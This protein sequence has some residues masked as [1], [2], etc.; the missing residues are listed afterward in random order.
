LLS[1]C[2]G[3]GHVRAA[4]SE[5]RLGARALAAQGAAAYEQRDFGRALELFERA[6]AL[7]PA[8][9]LKLMEARALVEL[10]RF[11]EAADRYTETERMLGREPANEAFRQAAK[12]AEVERAGVL[13]RTPS[14]RVEVVGAAP[15]DSV[16]L[17]IDG[18]PQPPE[19]AE[20]ARPSDPGVH[21]IEARTRSGAAGQSSVTL[22]EGMHADV[23]VRLV[24]AT[25][26]IA[27]PASPAPVAP[28]TPI[29][30]G[31]SSSRRTVGWVMAASGAAA[32]VV[33]AV[34]G[35]MALN[36]KAALDAVCDPL[37]PRDQAGTI[38]A[39]R[40][41]RTTSYVAFGV[42]ALGLVG[43][44]YLIVSD[45]PSKVALTIAPNRVALG[46]RF[47]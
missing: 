2:L 5:S 19:T 14:L 34:S 20:Q 16:E 22:E 17:F 21:R 38:D 31:P 36:D 45:R 18:E 25:A 41:S 28:A 23:E 24:S 7:V 33:G 1:F 15:G 37:C 10:G 40:T 43:G 11:V 3:A 44:T 47:P 29:G 42:G 32:T 13:E 9:T 30:P 46:G 35:I 8:P 12:S 27:V 4:D 26:S 39:F 6:S